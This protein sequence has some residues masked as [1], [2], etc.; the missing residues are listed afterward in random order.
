MGVR[1]QRKEVGVG[2]SRGPYGFGRPAHGAPPDAQFAFCG[3]A[4]PTSR[5]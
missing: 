4:T 2:D 3:R 1:T 5:R